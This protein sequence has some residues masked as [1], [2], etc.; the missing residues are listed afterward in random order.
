[1]A[2]FS[3]FEGVALGV[4]RILILLIA[5]PNFL[6]SKRSLV[7]QTAMGSLCIVPKTMRL[8]ASVELSKTYQTFT[9]QKLVA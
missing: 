6:K 8:Q 7:V 9:V 3:F 5:P 1:L 2:S 4:V